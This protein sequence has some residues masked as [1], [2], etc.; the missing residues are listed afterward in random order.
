[1]ADNKNMSVGMLDNAD[2]S[3]HASGSQATLNLVGDDHRDILKEQRDERKKQM[4]QKEH[5]R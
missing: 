4:D 3:I 5:E 1:M 2:S